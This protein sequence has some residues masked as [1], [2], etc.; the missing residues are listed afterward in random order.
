MLYIKFSNF[1]HEMTGFSYFGER[2][3]IVVGLQN[4][5]LGQRM[6]A[7]FAMAPGAANA[8]ANFSVL[9]L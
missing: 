7:H 4:E 8:A 3:V 9:C 1:A 5:F 2:P 6:A